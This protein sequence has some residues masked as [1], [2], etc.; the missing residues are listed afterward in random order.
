MRSL[1]T[2]PS[3]RPFWRSL[4]VIAA[5]LPGACAMPPANPFLGAW[6]TPERNAITFR[7][8][9]VIVTPTGGEAPTE[10]SAQACAGRFHF[11]YS[12][13]SRDQLAALIERQ[14][15]LRAQLDS[16]LRQPEY[17]V[18]ELGCDQGSN[19]YV[20]LDDRDLVAIYRDGDIAAVERLSRI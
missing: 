20:L 15:D 18:A 8:A 11:G 5:V 10:M 9:T 19:T 6:A 17:P 13:K 4:L 3:S 16:L 14:P 7:D 2:C 1:Q 12:R